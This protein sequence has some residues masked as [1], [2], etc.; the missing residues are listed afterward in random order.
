MDNFIL[1]IMDAPNMELLLQNN[2]NF[3]RKELFFRLIELA[4][5]ETDEIQ[6]VK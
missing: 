4:N 3:L 6:K 2:K 5:T 1:K